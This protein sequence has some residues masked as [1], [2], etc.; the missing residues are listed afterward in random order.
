MVRNTGG[1]AWQQD[2]VRARRTL[3]V[4]ETGIRGG[5][6]ATTFGEIIGLAVDRDGRIF[7]GDRIGSTV[8]AYGSDGSHLGLVGGEGKGPGEFRWP[9]ALAIGPEGRLFVAEIGGVTVMASPAPGEIPTEQ[10]RSWQPVARPQAYRPLRVTCGG[11][12]YFPHQENRPMRHFYLRVGSD[13]TLTDTVRVP[14]MPG[15]PPNVPWY[16]TG[17]GGGRMLGGVDHVPLGPTP[18]WDVTPEG[19]LLVGESS[20]YRLLMIAPGGDTVRAVRRRV[21]RRAIP[22]QVRRESTEALRTRLD[23]LPVPVDDVNNLPDSVANLD[24]PSR[25]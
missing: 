9:E 8:R 19:R 2:T 13:G 5:A 10:V 21:E 15:V 24:L 22:T 12:V 11:R 25:Y 1:G 6:E 14:G 23:T 20:R 3:L 18:S 7:V 16:R 4:G 17:P